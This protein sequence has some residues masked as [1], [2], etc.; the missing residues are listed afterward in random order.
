[1]PISGG[2]DYSVPQ[3]FR[4]SLTVCGLTSQQP[5]A[6]P[7]MWSKNMQTTTD[8]N[9]RDTPDSLQVRSG[10]PRTTTQLENVTGTSCSYNDRAT[11]LATGKV[12]GGLVSATEG[13]SQESVDASHGVLDMFKTMV[14]LKVL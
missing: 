1:H 11:L 14:Q 9:N 3:P 4:E 13:Q 10:F 12:G 7:V 2:V 6:N 8:L 5:Y